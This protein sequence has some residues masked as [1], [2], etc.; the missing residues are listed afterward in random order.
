MVI[1]NS[2]WETLN[3]RTFI[4]ADLYGQRKEE[5]IRE[6]IDSTNCLDSN[7]GHRLVSTYGSNSHSGVVELSILCSPKGMRLISV[8]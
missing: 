3:S 5:I 8:L 7:G 6:Y 2:V 4:L 1:G